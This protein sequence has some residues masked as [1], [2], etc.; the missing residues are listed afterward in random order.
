MHRIIEIA[1]GFWNI[2]GAFRIRGVIDIGTHASLVRVKSGG[3]VFLDSYTLS[4]RV[5]DTVA[6]L[7]DSGRRVEAIVNLH[8]FH[9]VHVKAVAAAFPNAKLYG[10]RRH[11]K[12]F[13][14]LRWEAEPTE[15]EPF[16]DLFREDFDFTVPLGV[17]FVPANENLHFASVLA[18]HRASRTLH[19]DD[20]L[21]W[22]PWPAGSRLAFHPTL[23]AVLERRPGAVADFRAWAESL[24]ERCSTIDHVCTAHA[25]AA[26]VTGADKITAQVTAALRRVRVALALHEARYPPTA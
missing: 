24:I 8:P 21:N 18:I 3:F 15:G 20:T 26:D 13:P 2:R 17:Q 4:G 16:A 9:T 6:T 10:T 7:T 12:R 14:D 19:V 23:P 5:A 1:E 25:R 22:L 11:V